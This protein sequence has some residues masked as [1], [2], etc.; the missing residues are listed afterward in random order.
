MKIDEIPYLCVAWK[1]QIPAA[2][3]SKK[4]PSWSI[5]L[6]EILYFCGGFDLNHPL[7]SKL[8]PGTSW[9]VQ[10]VKAGK[11]KLKER[12]RGTVKNF[13]LILKKIGFDGSQW[14]VG[15][16]GIW[17]E[18]MEFDWIVYGI[19]GDLWGFVEISYNI[20]GMR[21][22]IISP[23]VIKGGLLRNPLK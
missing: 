6:S 8:H 12:W 4:S 5:L 14:I 17:W 2:W 18:L 16:N 11:E 9:N 20:A 1:S 13:R 23:P 19:L 15:I 21:I 10:V 3:E 22:G 7:C